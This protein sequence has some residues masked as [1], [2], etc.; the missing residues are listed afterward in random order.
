MYRKAVVRVPSV[1]PSQGQTNPVVP[2]TYFMLQLFLYYMLLRMDLAP[3]LINF[4]WGGTYITCM[5]G[6]LPVMQELYLKFKNRMLSG[7]EYTKNQRKEINSPMYLIQF[8]YEELAIYS[9][10]I[11][12][13]ARGHWQLELYLEF[14]TQTIVCWIKTT[15]TLVIVEWEN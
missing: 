6:C 1:L 13:F 12:I 11:W 5:H 9:R 7:S 15:Q 14:S 2:L 4:F 3:Q 10:S 8:F